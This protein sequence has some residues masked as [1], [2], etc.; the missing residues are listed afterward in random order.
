MLKPII[1]FVLPCYNEEKCLEKTCKD[2]SSR[3]DGLIKKKEISP[4]SKIVFVDDGSKDATWSVIMA[5]AGKYDDVV[6]VKLAHNVGHQN[7]LLAGLIYASDY[8]DAVISMDADLQDNLGVI[9][10][11]LE[12]Y[13]EGYEV[14][15]GVRGSRETDSAFKRWTAQTFYKVMRAMGVELVYNAADCRLMSKRAVK[16]LANYSEV[17]LF[18]RGVVPLIGL[19]STTVTYHRDKRVAGES[20]YPLRKMLSFAWD[21]ITSFSVKPIRM[22][23][24]VGLIVFILSLFVMLYALVV[25]ATGQTVS[26][27]TFTICSIWL[28]A[29]IQMMSIGLIGEYIG[30]VYAETK[31]RPRYFIEQV[32]NDEKGEMNGRSR[33]G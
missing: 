9:D 2:L 23:L 20:K 6:G 1:Y 18:L 32:T 28:V 16:Q 25:W 4:K 19:K 8:A 11:F 21:G 29:G 13:K 26:G 27:W 17:N 24:A 15:Y 12:K 30:K 10:G 31:R 33:K 22:V 14:V 3:M 5:L 7:A